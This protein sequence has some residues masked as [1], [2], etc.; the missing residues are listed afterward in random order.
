M[1]IKEMIKFQVM[2]QVG[3]KTTSHGSDMTLSSFFFQLIFMLFMSFMDDIGKFISQSIDQ[4]KQCFNHYCKKQITSS[5]SHLPLN[6]SKQLKDTSIT[7]D[8]RH[9][10]AILTMSRLYKNA[11]TSDKG[12]NTNNANDESNSMVDAILNYISKLHNIPKFNLIENGRFVITY[13]DKP[14]QISKDIYFKI[15]AINSNPDGDISMLK[16]SLL[17]NSITASEIMTFVKN[18]YTDFLQELKN[19]L[20]SNVYYFDQKSRDNKPPPPAIMPGTS[21]DAI[22]TTLMNHKSMIINTAPK[23]L[24]Y[25]MMTFYSNKKFSN[26]YGHEARLIEKRVNFFIKN[27][28]WYDQKGIPYQLGLMLSGLP[29]CGKTSIIR[30]IANLTKRHIINI[31]FSNILSA[32]QLKTLFYSDKIQVYTDSS[33]S[34]TQTFFIPIDQRLYV[35]EEV[36]AIGDIVKK[37]NLVKNNNENNKMTVNDEMT[38]MEILTVLD[39]TMEVPGRMLIMTSNH[40]EVLDDALIRPGRIDIKVNFSNASQD[41]IIEMYEGYL[42]R[43]FPK[44]FSYRLPDG[45]LTPA[46]VSQVLFKFHGI[47]DFNIEDVLSEL[48]KDQAHM[49]QD[50][51]HMDHDYQ[52]NT[53]QCKS[54]SIN[55]KKYVDETIKRYKEWSQK[56]HLNQFLPYS[57]TPYK[58]IKDDN[59]DMS[60]PYESVEGLTTNSIGLIKSGEMLQ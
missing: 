17:S 28:D 40:P 36:D 3:A 38:L 52:Y 43:E 15:D 42:E 44:Q 54:D 11:T 46:E 30:A 7:L 6:A 49:D 27:K 14:I 5:I 37:R 25:T 26:I 60:F 45:K 18:I 9:E 50:Q 31:N 35:L 33:M 41:Q 8:T 39:G 51:A 59:I 1:D 4:S 12:N 16:I 24:S 2:S 13:K 23:Q 48:N 53:I 34:Q 57:S 21:E 19:S 55:T 10:I 22:R 29:G 47:D 20:G 58:E 56:V 32:T